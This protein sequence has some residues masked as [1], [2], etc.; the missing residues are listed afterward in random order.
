MKKVKN[1]IY[2]LMGAVLFTG[3]A[4]AD[5]FAGTGAAVPVTGDQNSPGTYVAIGL[6]AAA[7]IVLLLFSN[8]KKH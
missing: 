2:I 5:S 3:T 1:L 8:K 7:I 6:G 4:M